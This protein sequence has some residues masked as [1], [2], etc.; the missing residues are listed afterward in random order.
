LV[1][2]QSFK[3][4]FLDVLAIHNVHL[5][6]LYK[7]VKTWRIT[8][9]N[10]N[11]RAPKLCQNCS[12]S[13]SSLRISF[14]S[15]YLRNFRVW[16]SL[17]LICILSTSDCISSCHTPF[18]DQLLSF[19]S[20]FEPILPNYFLNILQFISQHFISLFPDILHVYISTFY[21]SILQ[22]FYSFFLSFYPFK[23]QLFYQHF[24]CLFFNISLLFSRFTCLFKLRN[25]VVS[26][27]ISAE[28]Y[29]KIPHLCSEGTILS[30]II[31][32]FTI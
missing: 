3:R 22:A 16:K 8:R 31:F 10:N 11:L 29:F 28:R 26:D 5:T 30:F 24:I 13:K 17:Y 7:G 1:I 14:Q 21:L 23:S 9:L 15:S 18:F 6:P 4:L 2:D 12:A 27:K 25:F 32:S 19:Y 20:S